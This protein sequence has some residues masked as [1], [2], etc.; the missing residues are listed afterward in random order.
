MTKEVSSGYE[1]ACHSMLQLLLSLW[2]RDYNC[3]T[4][5]TILFLNSLNEIWKC[6]LLSHLGCFISNPLCWCTEAQWQKKCIFVEIFVDLTLCN[7]NILSSPTNT[8][9]ILELANIRFPL[10]FSRPLNPGTVYRF[11][12]CPLVAWSTFYFYSYPA[13]LIVNKEPISSLLGLLNVI[14]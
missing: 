12:L 2:K 9:V 4:V 6:A 10:F 8:S 1:A 7:I 13:N 3:Y 5:K 11:D 14:L